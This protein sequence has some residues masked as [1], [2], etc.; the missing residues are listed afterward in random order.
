MKLLLKSLGVAYGMYFNGK[1]KRRGPVFQQRYR[2]SR[3]EEDDY[4]LHISRYIHLNPEKYKVW[5]WS[6]LPYYLGKFNA[7]WIKPEKILELF[8][9][10]DYSKFIENYTAHQKELKSLK[11]LLADNT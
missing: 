5:K 8:Q 10:D 2:A 9:G 11:R 6:S 4:L 1:Y 7:D 3:I